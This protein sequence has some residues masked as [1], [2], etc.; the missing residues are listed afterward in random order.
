MLPHLIPQQGGSTH[1]EAVAIHD[2]AASRWPSAGSCITIITDTGIM[3]LNI[4]PTHMLY[5]TV[6]GQLRAS[7]HITCLRL[8]QWW[9]FVKEG[10]LHLPFTQTRWQIA[11]FT[12][13]QM[14]RIF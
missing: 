5:V 2:Y 10:I 7:R 8:P 4:P 6:H 13:L 14:W 1:D 11:A 12:L 9:L 3:E